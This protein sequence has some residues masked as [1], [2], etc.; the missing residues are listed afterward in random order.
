MFKCVLTISQHAFVFPE[1]GRA[2]SSQGQKG[3]RER[4]RVNRSYAADGFVEKDMSKTRENRCV[5]KINKL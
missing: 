5:P 1:K 4:W 3:T 2:A